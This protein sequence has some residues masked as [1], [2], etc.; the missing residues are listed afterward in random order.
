MKRIAIYGIIVLLLGL[1]LPQIIEA[2]RVSNLTQ[3][4]GLELSD[5][6]T[7]F[8]SVTDTSSGILEKYYAD[9]RPRFQLVATGYALR[10]RLGFWDS[11]WQNAPENHANLYLVTGQRVSNVRVIEYDGSHAKMLARIQWHEQRVNRNTLMVEDESN[12][13]ADRTYWFVLEDG[14]WKVSDFESASRNKQ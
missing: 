13:A 9:E 14:V 11:V 10:A 1:I 2:I 7:R 5:V 12:A 8:E 6:A 4:Y 3:Q